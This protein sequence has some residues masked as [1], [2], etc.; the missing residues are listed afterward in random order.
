MAQTNQVVNQVVYDTSG[1]LIKQDLM[2]VDNTKGSLSFTNIS[3][4]IGTVGAA[5][6]ASTIFTPT[7]SGLYLLSFY[8]IATTPPSGADAAPNLYMK[9]TD[10]H[11]TQAYFNFAGNLDPVY[12]D[13]ANQ[14]T[15][16]IYATAGTPIWM[17]TSAGNYSG[18]I[19]WSFYFSVTQL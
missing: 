7:V 13:G 2:A 19:R 1:R 3:A 9:W 16:P 11:G 5:T 17:A 6:P 15:I 14:V 18:T 10:E 4:D 12:S 8:G